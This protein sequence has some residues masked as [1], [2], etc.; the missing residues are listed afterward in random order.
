VQPVRPE[1]YDLYLKARFLMNQRTPQALRDAVERLDEVLRQEP[2]YALAW[3]AKAEC[4]SHLV[5]PGIAAMPAREGVAK[6]RQAAAKAIELDPSLSEAHT[7]LGF[8][9]TESWEWAAA[10]KAF[11]RAIE[12]NPSNTDAYMKYAFY[13]TAMGRHKESLAALETAKRLDPLS[14]GVNQVTAAAYRFAGDHDRAITAARATLEGQPGYWFGHF[15]LGRSYSSQG[16][17]ADADA[18]LRRALEKGPGPVVL[19]AIG[20]N[21]VRW[22]KPAE[23]RRVL[24]D[25]QGKR[26]AGYVPPT[27][28]AKLHFA[29]GET[30]DGFAWLRKALDERDQGMMFLNVDPDYEAVRADARFKRLVKEVGLN[31]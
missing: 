27:I 12:L 21:H 18:E 1:T 2:R 30:G 19:G 9:T 23:A 24:A 5:S 15:I 11:R 31:R 6:A 22:G 14:A 8:A 20:S 3:A 7:V 10:E 16:R 25:L 4:Y 13:L 29:L 28:L 17:F 26:K